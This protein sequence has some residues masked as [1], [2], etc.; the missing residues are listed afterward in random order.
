MIESCQEPFRGAA[1]RLFR[2]TSHVLRLT[3]HGS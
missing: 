3:F 1:F 2:L